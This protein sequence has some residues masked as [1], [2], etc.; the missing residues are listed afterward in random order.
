ME[1]ID[2]RSKE[3]KEDSRKFTIIKVNER[4]EFEAYF[5]RSGASEG[6]EIQWCSRCIWQF[7][8]FDQALDLIKALDEQGFKAGGDIQIVPIERCIFCGDWYV[9]PPIPTGEPFICDCRTCRK[10]K[11]NT[12]S[13]LVSEKR[14]SVR[15]W[16]LQSME[17]EVRIGVIIKKVK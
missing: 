16:K 10:R 8:T 15:H 1:L 11:E 4:G 7:D 6:K 3:Q 14:Q 2:T 13:D 17:N 9:A 12:M 5:L